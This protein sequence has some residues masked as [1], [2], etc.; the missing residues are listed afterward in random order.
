MP[1]LLFSGPFARSVAPLCMFRMGDEDD[2]LHLDAR[3]RA[4]V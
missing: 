1:A 2:A 3:V 4:S